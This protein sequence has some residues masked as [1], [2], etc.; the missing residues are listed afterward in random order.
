MAGPVTLQDIR[1]ELEARVA[2]LRAVGEVRD[3]WVPRSESRDDGGYVYAVEDGGYVFAARERGQEHG[4]RETDSLDELLFWCLDSVVMAMAS[5]W[6]VAHRRAGEDARRQLFARRLELMAALDEA[7]APRL[8]AQ[9]E[10]V[11]ERNPYDDALVGWSGRTVRV[12]TRR[13]WRRRSAGALELTGNDDRVREAR[14]LVVQVAG[15]PAPAGTGA[16]AAATT[17]SATYEFQLDGRR[18]V[19]SEEELT[20]E[21]RRLAELV[22]AGPSRR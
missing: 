11:L 12:R 1:R 2:R 20:P 10:R 21:L 6:E 13:R 5:E 17:G 8:R 16:A 9:L 14:R 19:V 7:W 22:L 3:A 15:S 4:R 18:L